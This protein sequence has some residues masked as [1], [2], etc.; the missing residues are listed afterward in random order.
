MPTPAELRQLLSDN[1]AS[2]IEVDM[3]FLEA[4]Q[5][6]CT[7]VA[8]AAGRSFHMREAVRLSD[9]GAIELYV[10]YVIFVPNVGGAA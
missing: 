8:N 1:P 10:K 3:D 5:I 6:D 9:S 4:N 7:D 2:E